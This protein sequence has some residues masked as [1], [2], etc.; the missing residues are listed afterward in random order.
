MLICIS[1]VKDV[2]AFRHGHFYFPSPDEQ[3]PNHRGWLVGNRF[4]LQMNS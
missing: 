4:R 1:K 3:V 2:M